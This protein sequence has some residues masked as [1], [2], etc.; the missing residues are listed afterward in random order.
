MIPEQMPVI[1][2]FD[3][4]QCKDC[5]LKIFCNIQALSAFKSFILYKLLLIYSSYYLEFGDNKA[6]IKST[7]LQGA[8]NCDAG[9]FKWCKKNITRFVLAQY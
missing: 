9:R 2:F 6:M 3:S 8:E 7:E 4:R 1:T 5:G